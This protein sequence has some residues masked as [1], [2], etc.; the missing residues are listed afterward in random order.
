MPALWIRSL[1]IALSIHAGGKHASAHVRAI[2]DFEQP[3]DGA[4]LTKS[5]VQNGEKNVQL[6][7]L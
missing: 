4:V 1:Q 7:D 3:L 6:C 5:A 2:Q